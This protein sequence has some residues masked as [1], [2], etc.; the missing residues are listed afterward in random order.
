[1]LNNLGGCNFTSVAGHALKNNASLINI[2]PNPVTEKLV[3]IRYQQGV[4]TVSVY[5]MTGKKM[6]EGKFRTG[7]NAMTIDVSDF[8]A[9]VYS[10]NVRSADY[11]TSVTKKLVV[12]KK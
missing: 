1:L 4:E 3:V 10:V 6:F 9:G 5:N 12:Q 11:K 7:L 8:P 2:F